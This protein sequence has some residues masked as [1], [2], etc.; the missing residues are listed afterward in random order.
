MFFNAEKTA[1]HTFRCQHLWHSDAISGPN[2]AIIGATSYTTHLRPYYTLFPREW[3]RT[4]G[5][6]RRW[7]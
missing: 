1:K 7:C 3:Q 2:S 6:I 5:C 4:I